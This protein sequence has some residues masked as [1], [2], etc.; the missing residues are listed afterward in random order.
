MILF[1][2]ILVQED[3]AIKSSDYT[4]QR[5]WKGYKSGNKSNMNNHKLMADLE[6]GGREQVPH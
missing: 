2:I 3:K 1:P 6:N 4:L 5:V